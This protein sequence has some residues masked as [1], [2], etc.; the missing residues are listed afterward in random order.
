MDQ[1]TAIVIADRAA[2]LALQVLAAANLLFLG[3]FLASLFIV[4][5]QVR[6]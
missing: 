4:A 6:F 3:S 5:E 1:K 2:P